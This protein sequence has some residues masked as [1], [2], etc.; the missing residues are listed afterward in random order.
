MGEEE[1]KPM[2]VESEEEEVPEVKVDLLGLD[3][4]EVED[5]NDVG[6][7]MPLMRDFSQAEWAIL[8]LRY[9]LHLLAHSFRKDVND[10]ERAGIHLDHLDFYYN[11][12]FRRQLN[13][14]RFGCTTLAEV[15]A[16]ARDTVF[17][18]EGK[19]LEALLQE[20]QESLQVFVKLVE[21][22]RR[23]RNIRFDLGE[24]NARLK[25]VQEN[26]NNN[27]NNGNNG[28]Q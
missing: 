20:D 19:I 9:E 14:K 10:P 28:N 4:F 18:T 27:W 6:G 16:L 15:V 26:T 7:G 13:P 24:P 1:P 11:K 22:D 2:E 5:V 12:Y 3:V 21:E 17:V 23:D 25:I 8:N